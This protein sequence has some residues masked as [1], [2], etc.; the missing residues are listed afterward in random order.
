MN[1]YQLAKL[2]AWAGTLHTRKRLQK[3]VFMLQSAG[4]PLQAEYGLH[5][6][7][8]Y[9]EDVAQLTDE[10][11]E[12]KLLTEREEKAGSGRQFHYDLAPASAKRL[13]DAEATPQGREWAEEMKPYE[14]LARELL[15]ADLKELE[16]AATIAFFRRQTDEW[17]AAVEKAG[18]FKGLAPNSPLLTAAE[19][20]ARKVLP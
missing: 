16:I 20:L 8:P 14:P 19:A 10:L 2:V 5:L 18:R 7:G 6:F 3:L 11:V 9:S 4:C 1:R 17:P 15:K 12:R 13:V